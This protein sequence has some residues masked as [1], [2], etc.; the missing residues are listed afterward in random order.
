MRAI[1]ALVLIVAVGAAAAFFADHPGRVEIVWPGWQVETSVGVLVAAVALG[2]LLASL[3][4][5]LLSALRRWPGNFRRRRAAR[6][7][8]TGEA[9]LTSGLVAL[10]AGDPA[11]AQLAARRAEALLADGQLGGSP[12]ALLLAAEAAQRQGDRAEARRA[13]TALLD[14][15][16]S[17]FL[18][19]RGLIGQALRAGEDDI[20]LHLA[21]RARKLRP[22]ARWLADAL[23]QLAARAGN[24]AAVRD[25]LADAARRKL[26]PPATARH[27]RGIVLH[28]LS[29]AAE[30]A[31]DKRRAAGLAAKAQ[32]LSPDVVAVAAHHARLLIG[33]GRERT[34][35]KAIERAW[36][37]APHPELARLYLDLHPEAGALARVGAAQR[38][39][40][41]NPEAEES[42]IAIAGAA[43]GA[44][45]WGEARRH[46]ALAAAS[47][48]VSPGSSSSGSSASGPS[49]R[50][51]LLMARLEENEPG[52]G[53]GPAAR[54]WLDRAIGAPLD[55]CYVCARCGGETS[56]WLALCPECGGFDTLGWQTP[57]SASRLLPRLMVAE[58]ASAAGALMLLAPELPGDTPR[59]VPAELVG[60][61]EPATPRPPRRFLPWSRASG[62][63][64][65]SRWDK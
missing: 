6:R 62:L 41:H 21:A 48:E 9:A 40:A 43:L 61:I 42:R 29:R 38:L 36:R 35:A 24:W 25:T 30:R 28:E 32:A 63:A 49:R 11:Q 58:P 23:I 10:A 13:Y 16:G 20:A 46:L 12:V 56:E 59:Q 44:Q 54:D 64:R 19:L 3:L 39:A 8:R 57:P 14:R 18:G 51:C 60:G 37:S 33:L 1:A 50:L 26:L 17:E 47:H 2:A 4:A 34:A 7:R 53:S 31:G 15:P 65:P 5:L 55:P 45:L 27:H 22:D 52:N